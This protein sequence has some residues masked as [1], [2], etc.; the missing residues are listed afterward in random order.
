[1]DRKLKKRLIAFTVPPYDEKQRKE[2]LLLAKQIKEH[3]PEEKMSGIRFFFDQL[4]FI[5]KRTWLLKIA[6]T[7]LFTG[8]CHWSGRR[9]GQLSAPAWF[10]VYAAPLSDQC[11]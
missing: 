9:T 5:R 7:A 1:M 3:R 8:Y 4:R 11:P 2:T 10:R 6:A